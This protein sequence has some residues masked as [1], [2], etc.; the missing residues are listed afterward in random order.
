[1]LKN[2]LKI[3]VRNINR[4]RGFSMLNIG[5]LAIGSQ[6]CIWAIS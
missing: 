6:C 4:N 3:A 2:F 5:G 1:M